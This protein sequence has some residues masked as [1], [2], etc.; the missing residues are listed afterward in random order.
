MF[1]TWTNGSTLIPTISTKFKSN[2][3]FAGPRF[4]PIQPLT[5]KVE[6]VEKLLYNIKVNK[7][8]GPDNI[9]CRFLPKLSAELAPML[10]VIFQQSLSTGKLP[11]DWL[12]A[13]V[14]HIFKK[15]SKNLAGQYH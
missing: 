3:L 5:I 4:P 10:T 11:S 12:K 13:E 9:P 8:S 15:G 2:V 7:A 14:A 6:G 1:G